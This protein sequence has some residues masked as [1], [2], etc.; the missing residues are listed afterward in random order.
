MKK[1]VLKKKSASLPFYTQVPSADNFCI[2]FGPRSGPTIVQTVGGI[3]ER[4]FSKKMVL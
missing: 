2:Q 4:M 3:P 1:I